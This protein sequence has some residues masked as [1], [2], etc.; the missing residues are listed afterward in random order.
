MISE[1]I[2]IIREENLKPINEPK[3]SNGSQFNMSGKFDNNFKQS[4]CDNLEEMFLHVNFM[5]NAQFVDLH[6]T[7]FHITIQQIC[8]R[9]RPD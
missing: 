4:Y 2:T 6:L 8:D 1:K 5:A 7:H 9:Q 3:V